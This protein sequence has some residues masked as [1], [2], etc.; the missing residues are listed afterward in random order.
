MTPATPTASA[1]S[2]AVT[3]PAVPAPSLPETRTQPR[4]EATATPAT[5]DPTAAAAGEAAVQGEDWIVRQDANAYTVQLISGADQKALL[6]FIKAHPLTDLAIFE[7]RREGFPWYSLIQ[8][9]YPDL[10]GARSAAAA[11]PPGVQPWI[12]RMGE[13][14][15]LIAN[16]AR[17]AG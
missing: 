5:A 16:R 6:R 13:I 1:P 15:M 9:A 4:P 11:L 10:T 12:R 2:S 7:G 8:G 3:A 17:P 14:Q